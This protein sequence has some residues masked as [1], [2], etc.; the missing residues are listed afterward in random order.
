[1]DNFWI[2]HGFLLLIG[3]TLFPRLSILM[4]NIPGG[5]FFWIIWIVFPRIVIAFYASIL[6]FDT[7]PILVFL[8]WII[9]LS[10][11]STEKSYG[12]KIK[13]QKTKSVKES[14]YE[15]IDE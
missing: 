3:L 1:M 10:G 13:N 2:Y 4:C 9:A 7:N 11:E 14:E 8:S 5:L 15:L 6:Y 12:Y